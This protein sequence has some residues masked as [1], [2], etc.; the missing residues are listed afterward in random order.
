LIAKTLVLNLVLF[1]LL[2]LL[3]GSGL[4]GA[5][6]VCDD[7]D[8][9]LIT[10][11]EDNCQDIYNPAQ[12]D[13]DSDAVGDPCDA[14]TPIHDYRFA[15]CYRTNWSEL[16]GPNWEDI[17]FTIYEPGERNFPGLLRWPDMMYDTLEEGPG[18]H[19]GRDIWFMGQWIGVEY[20]T[21]TYY[22]GPMIVYIDAA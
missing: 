17:E 9:D 14:T 1:G 18:Q 2:A 6:P 16:H 15:R 4:L 21:A 8:W 22:P 20:A 5:Q 3:A 7:V 10:D 13:E 11:E 19:N 12:A